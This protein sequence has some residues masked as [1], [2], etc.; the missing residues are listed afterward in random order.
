M[1][2]A[3][4]LSI[5]LLSAFSAF[6]AG[7]WWSN[8][9]GQLVSEKDSFS[10]TGWE[11]KKEENASTLF[12]DGKE[13]WRK[14]TL[15]DGE[16]KVEGNLETRIYLY[17][18]GRIKSKIED[19]GVRK[20]EYNYNYSSSLTISS[21]TISVDGVVEE[22]LEYI[23][24]PDGILLLVEKN[25]NPI[26]FSR[27]RMVVAEDGIVSSYLY[28]EKEESD[29]TWLDDGG[30]VENKEGGYRKYDGNGR[31]VEAKDEESTT[32]YT[33]SPEGALTSSLTLKAGKTIE[34]TYVNSAPSVVVTRNENGDIEKKRVTLS[35]G[36]F[37]ETRY[38]E[39]KPRYRYQPDKYGE[40]IQ[41]GRGR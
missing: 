10:G 3:L 8:A 5:L 26:Y 20:V 22:R 21:S 15:P 14:E 35:D 31:L 11:L 25:G 29:T 4:L 23:T 34:T 17:P 32:T 36:T 7:Y 1:K 33:Y 40:R 19:D 2:K 13:V 41:A 12:L 39:G 28:E 38:L 18:D 9:L 16:R 6:G 24:S 27:D 37:E 30:Y